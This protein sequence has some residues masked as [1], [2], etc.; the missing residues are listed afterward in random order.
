MICNVQKRSRIDLPLTQE[1][2]CGIIQETVLYTKK[3][4]SSVDVVFV[5]ESTARKLNKQFRKYS[6][7]PDVLTFPDS[8]IVVAPVRVRTQVKQLG[9]SF[10]DE[11]AHILVHGTLHLLGHIHKDMRDEE[12]EILLRLGYK[13][14]H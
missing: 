9:I 14:P 10:K 6:Y 12:N 3:K 13:K 5:G 7:V 8:E 1:K 11:L 4:R 2:I